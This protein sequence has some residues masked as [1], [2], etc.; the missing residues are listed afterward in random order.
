MNPL[1]E[2]LAQVLE[3]HPKVAAKYELQLEIDGRRVHAPAH[4][5]E[6]LRSDAVNGL[7]AH[8]RPDG[9]NPAPAS[10]L[11]QQIQADQGLSASPKPDAPPFRPRF[12][13][14]EPSEPSTG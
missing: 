7:T 11:V 1:V 13:A 5:G 8:A 14:K 12:G 3:E 4:L 2:A 9:R 6:D 10:M